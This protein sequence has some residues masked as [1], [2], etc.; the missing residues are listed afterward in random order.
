MNELCFRAPVERRVIP[1]DQPL[2]MHI[3]QLIT[4]CG[5]FEYGSE[6]NNGYGCRAK[7]NTEAPGC[8][9]TFACPIA[10]ELDDEDDEWDEDYSPGGWMKKHSVFED[11]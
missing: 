7:Q 8:C 6:L 1:I 5:M 2:V 4:E 3:D 9:H 11:V 10:V